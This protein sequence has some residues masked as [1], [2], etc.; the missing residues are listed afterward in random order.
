MKIGMD[1]WKGNW[2]GRNELVLNTNSRSVELHSVEKYSPKP[3]LNN[4]SSTGEDL[5]RFSC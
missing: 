1:Y 2:E 5:L 3:K 4:I